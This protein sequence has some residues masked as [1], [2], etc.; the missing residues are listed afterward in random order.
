MLFVSPEFPC[1]A[2]SGG[3]LR[4]ISLLHCLARHFEIH[5][6]TFAEIQPSKKDSECLRSLV[7]EL[8]ILPLRF[9]RRTKLRRYVRNIGRLLRNVPP[10]VDRF[11]ESGNRQVLAGMLA[12]KTDYVWLEHLWLAPYV[13]DIHRAAIKILDAHNVESDFY[14]QLRQASRHPLDHLGYRVFEKAARKI[15][16]RYLPCFDRILAVSE[17]DRRLL[18]RDAADRD[19]RNYVKERFTAATGSVNFSPLPCTIA[20]NARSMRSQRLSRSIA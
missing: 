1:P 12:M 9:H 4:T 13:A 7:A 14:G 19:V 3:R 17:E 20:P 6:V 8:T 11:A 16:R 10:L 15:E 5:C 2:S 18:A